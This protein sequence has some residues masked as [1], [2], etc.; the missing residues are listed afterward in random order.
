MNT[1]TVKFY[2][3]EKGYG[4]IIPENGGSEVFFHATGLSSQ[5]KPKE[6]D[7]VSYDLEDTDRGIN[8]V[9]VKIQ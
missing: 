2:N 8:A 7:K 5:D 1:G 6:Q 9:N 3:R 4:F